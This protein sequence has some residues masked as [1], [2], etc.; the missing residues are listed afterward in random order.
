MGTINYKIIN[1][2]LEKNLFKKIQTI[3]FSNKINWFF[4]KHMTFN[5][6][7]NYFFSHVFYNNHMPDS[8]L[9]ND[10]IPILEKL[11]VKSLIEARANLILKKEEIFKSEFHVDKNYKCNTAILY[12]NTCNGY[13]LLDSIKNIKVD[14]DENKM[15]IF[16]S[17]INHS[18]VSQTDVDR[19]I[20]I[21]FNYF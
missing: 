20:I 15:L 16:D 1:N 5:N 11:N 9:Y 18:A 4:N 10:I 7:D 21:N 8:L 13:T 19:R 17:Q 2:F 12:M 6:N 14:C 3:L